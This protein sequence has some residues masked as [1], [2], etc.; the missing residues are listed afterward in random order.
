MPGHQGTSAAILENDT[1]SLAD[2]GMGYENLS[3][4]D[5]N[6]YYGRTGYTYGLAV[7]QP[8][9]LTR[10]KFTDRPWN[11]AAQQ[12]NPLKVWDPFTIIP[13][14]NYRGSPDNG[15]FA[16]GIGSLVDGT[17]WMCSGVGSARRCV[18]IVWPYGLFSYNRRSYQ[19]YSWH[20]TLLDQKRDASGTLYRRNRYVDPSTGRFTQED[21]IGLA[22]GLNLYGFAASD[23]I[24]FA[25]PFGLSPCSERVA[26]LRRRVQSLRRRVDQYEDAVRRGENDAV[27]MRNIAEERRGFEN[28]MDAYHRDGCDDDEDGFRGLKQEG[29]ELVRK[30]LPAPAIDYNPRRKPSYGSTFATDALSVSP[31]AAQQGAVAITGLGLLVLLFVVVSPVP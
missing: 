27:H 18:S 2:Q 16:D 9:S 7:D 17:Q 12:I 25:D 24:N 26:G 6:P 19:A 20:G 1:A 30:P 3:L 29:V 14:W 5:K 4:L 28:D 15:S 31:Q 21:P 13:H 8:L 23:P 10:V 22:G 11:Y